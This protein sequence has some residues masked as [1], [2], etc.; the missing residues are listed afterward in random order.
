MAAKVK[1]VSLYHKLM[2]VL[3]LGATV[4]FW[5]KAH[6]DDTGLIKEFSLPFVM[7]AIVLAL[8]GAGFGIAF[9]YHQKRQL[10]E[11]ARFSDPPRFN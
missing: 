2:A 5:G 9:H 4:M 11:L 7:G 3:L 8:L 1:R 10:A 6:K